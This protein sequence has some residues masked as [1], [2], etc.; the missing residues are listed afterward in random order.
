MGCDR[1]LWKGCSCDTPAP[2]SKLRKE[3]RRGCSYT[4]ARDTG[5]GG[6]A[7]APLSLLRRVLRR[8][9]YGFSVKT[10]FLEGFLEGG[11]L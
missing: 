11:V 9:L 10:R 2:H 5:G 6:V 1:A 8:R 4:L 7:S 3:P